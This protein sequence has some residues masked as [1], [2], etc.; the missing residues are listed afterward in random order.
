MPDR[1]TVIR[2]LPGN[3]A[4]IMSSQCE[5]KEIRIGRRVRPGDEVIYSPEDVCERRYPVRIVAMAASFL[6][7]CVVAWS[8]F[9]QAASARVYAQIAFQINPGFEI[10]VDRN[11]RVSS[12]AGFDDTGEALIKSANIVGKDLDGAVSEMVRLCLRRNYLNGRAPNY[13]AVSLYF[14]GGADNKEVLQRLDDRLEAELEE[15]GIDARVYFLQIDKNTRKQALKNRVSPIS[16]LLWQEAERRGISCD[17]R[18]GISLKDP[19]IKEIASRV[20]IRVGHSFKGKPQTDPGGSDGTPGLQKGGQPASPQDNGMNRRRPLNKPQPPEVPDT[21]GSRN[22]A[23]PAAV[24]DLLP[25][26]DLKAGR[27]ILHEGGEAGT[28]TAGDQGGNVSGRAG[29][30]S[31][32]PGSAMPG[33]DQGA[34]PPGGAATG[35]NPSKG[36]GRAG[37]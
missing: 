8:A 10:T 4:V 17:L 32:S 34:S 15:N 37:R 28:G 35:G 12:A 14:P 24:E 18:A 36:P 19:R 20:A 22:A 27:P 29:T 3:R 2:I 26:Q 5:F 11:L 30:G 23:P 21:G 1:G 33:N 7:L 31:N 9:Q 6:L 13:M 16:Y 25:Q